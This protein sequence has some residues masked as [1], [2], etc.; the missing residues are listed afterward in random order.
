MRL[1]K[2]TFASVLLVSLALIFISWGRTGHYKISYNTSLSFTQEMEPFMEWINH[3][4]DH[5]SDADYRRSED[6]NEGPRHYIDLDNYPEFLSD[7]SISQS[8]DSV[9]SQHGESF[10]YD[11]GV[12]PW[13]TL[14][15]YD[16][17]RECMIRK[18]WEKAKFFA[19]DLGHYVADGHMPMHITNNYNGQLTGNKGIHSRYESTMINANIDK[20]IYSGE[21]LQ[22]IE[23]I[24]AYVFDYL[25]ANYPYVDSIIEADNYATAIASSTSS[26]EYKD[27]LWNKTKDM[28]TLLFKNASQAMTELIFNAWVEAGK[29][30]LTSTSFARKHFDP[31]LIIAPNP[32]RGATTLS[33]TLKTQ[34]KVLLKICDLKGKTVAIVVNSMLEPSNYSMPWNA[35]NLPTGIYLIDFQTQNFKSTKKMILIN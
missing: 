10:V 18:D 7:G 16:S 26:T 4:A 15:S 23:N 32:Y 31:E 13:A 12:L 24:S 33:F 27:A 8:L 2:Q 28:T 21:E 17:L 30:S 1:K 22:P 3:L 35:D 6:T 9:L 11:A 14:Q 29:P 20:I 34:E 5:A 25:Y 19:A